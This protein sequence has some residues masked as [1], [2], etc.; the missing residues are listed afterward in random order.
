MDEGQFVVT[1]RLASIEGRLDL[2]KATTQGSAENVAFLRGL[3]SPPNGAIPGP[4]TFMLC[5]IFSSFIG[6]LMALAFV[7]MVQA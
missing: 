5:M 7:K 6:A 1:A 3:L 4:I 2:I